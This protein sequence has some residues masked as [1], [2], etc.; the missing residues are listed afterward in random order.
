M[1]KDIKIC[2]LAGPIEN[3]IDEGKKW[4]E[5]YSSLF[6]EFLDIE[7]IN[8]A[9]LAGIDQTELIRLKKTNSVLFIEKMRELIDRDLTIIDQVDIVVGRWDGEVSSGTIGEAQHAFLTGKPFYLVSPRPFTEIPGW[10]AACC[11]EIFETVG[12][13]MMFLGDLKYRTRP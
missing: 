13:L 11:S 6:K 7:S 1:A 3:T 5:E 2:Y 10:F 9:E 8:P 4:R 12:C